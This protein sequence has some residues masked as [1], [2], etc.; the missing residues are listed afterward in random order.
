VRSGITLDVT[1]VAEVNVTLKLGQATEVVEVTAEVPLLQ[2]ETTDVG[3][4]M[5][6]DAIQDIPLNLSTN[7]G[8]ELE[9]FAYQVTPGVEGGVWQNNISGTPAFSKQV[10]IDGTMQQG[11]ESGSISEDYPPLD[12]VQEFKVDSGGTS[13]QES[14]NTAGGAFMFSLKS[15]TNQFHGSA[16]FS[17][18]DEFLN[19]KPWNDNAYWNQS[20]RN[21]LDRMQDYAVSGGGPIIKNKTFF[22]AA[23]E[24]YRFTDFVD[25]GTPSTVPTTAFLNGDFSALLTSTPVPVS[26][27]APPATDAC[28]NPLY[29]GAIIDP[30]TGCYFDY[31]GKFNTIDPA[32]FS[33]VSKQIV[34]LYQ[35]YY[36]P[37]NAGLTDNAIFPNYNTPWF[38]QTQFSIKVDHAISNA[39]KLTSSFIYTDRPRMLINGGSG[40]GIWS[41]A[42]P[43]SGQTSRLE[44]GASYKITNRIVARGSYGL[45][46]VPIGENYWE[47]VP[48]NFAPGFQGTNI[49]PQNGTLP[50]F[51]WDSGYPGTFVP[52]TPGNKDFLTWGMVTVSPKSLVPGRVQEFSGGVE[53][54]P[55]R[56]VR[57]SLGYMGNRGQ[58]FA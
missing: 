57:V 35:Q 32:R 13:G 9:Q 14:T 21:P 41:N 18:Q 47:G 50:A 56:D 38:H 54:E 24:Q 53:I 27:G 29:V 4:T 10:L 45:S 3:A 17:M 7:Q 2:T 55:I 58:P 46:Y 16:Y 43:F 19:A 52:G 39:D 42:A 30:T 28:S 37:V 31:N 48:Y 1:Q 44:P 34:S 26:Q 12:A 5:T 36:Q 11:S 8:R 25:V 20:G 40:G 23:F 15:G 22:F 51:N 49:V 33:S 6:H